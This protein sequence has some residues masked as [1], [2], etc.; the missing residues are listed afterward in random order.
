MEYTLTVT[1]GIAYSFRHKSINFNGV[2]SYSPVFETIA[3]DLPSAPGHPIW[4]TSSIN[5]IQIFWSL[6]VDN[7]GCPIKEYRLYRDAGDGSGLTNTEI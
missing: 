1:T 6:S 3:C 5:S 7:G 4:I 2:S